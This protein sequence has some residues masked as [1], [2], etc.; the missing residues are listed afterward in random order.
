MVLL[1]KHS[2][3]AES[4]HPALLN[5]G[6]LWS[7]QSNRDLFSLL[8]PKMGANQ[9]S[10]S[11]SHLAHADCVLLPCRAPAPREEADPQPQEE[12]LPLAAGGRLPLLPAHGAQGGE[13]HTQL[14]GRER[15]PPRSSHTL[16]HTACTG[17]QGGEYHAQLPGGTRST[18]HPHSVLT[19][20]SY[21]AG[22]KLVV[23]VIVCVLIL[24]GYVKSFDTFEW[25]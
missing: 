23:D 7:G 22:N 12:H 21:W 10:V 17:P 20:S 11:L 8:S 14:P 3:R 4:N 25:T 9:S 18:P 15:S 24:V 6:R 2:G 13:H 1:H 19:C 5:R 16:Q